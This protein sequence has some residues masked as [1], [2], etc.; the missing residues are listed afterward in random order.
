M[1]CKK[2]AVTSRTL[3]LSYLMNN[4][5]VLHDTDQCQSH[6]C[7]S[8]CPVVGIHSCPAGSLYS[9]PSAV[10]SAE[11]PGCWLQAGLMCVCLQSSPHHGELQQLQQSLRKITEKGK[12]KLEAL[13]FKQG[14]MCN[15]YNSAPFWKC[16]ISNKACYGSAFLILLLHIRIV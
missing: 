1:Y 7:L 5:F 10:S 13:I 3:S 15:I 2:R 16:M 9:S 6:S 8:P 12:C 4:T 14:W 11:G